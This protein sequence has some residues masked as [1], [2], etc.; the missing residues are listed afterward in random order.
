M[1]RGAIFHGLSTTSS[2]RYRDIGRTSDGGWLAGCTGVR[3]DTS[4]IMATAFKLLLQVL[5]SLLL[6]LGLGDEGTFKG[7]DTSCSFTS[8]FVC[9]S[10]RK[11]DESCPRTLGPTFFSDACLFDFPVPRIQVACLS[12]WKYPQSLARPRH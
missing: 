12:K 4:S 2:T 7:L 3:V 10:W 9:Y 6:G 11:Y 1:A 8:I 5:A